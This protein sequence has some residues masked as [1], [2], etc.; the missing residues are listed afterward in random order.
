MIRMEISQ[1]PLACVA[2]VV[3]FHLRYGLGGRLR[4]G[5]FAG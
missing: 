1:T 3:S 4:G 5:S 2:A